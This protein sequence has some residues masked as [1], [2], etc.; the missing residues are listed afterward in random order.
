MRE[1]RLQTTK[2]FENTLGLLTHNVVYLCPDFKFNKPSLLLWKCSPTILI[3][4]NACATVSSKIGVSLHAL[5]TLCLQ[6]RAKFVYI[7][8][9]SCFCRPVWI[10]LLLSF[11]LA[12]ISPWSRHLLLM[13]DTVY[14]PRRRLGARREGGVQLS[15][16][17]DQSLYFCYGELRST[18]LS[19][20]SQKR[21]CRNR[22]TLIVLWRL[23]FV[24]LEVNH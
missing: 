20:L 5:L 22:P 6:T 12:F 23:M 8:G 10:P 4:P 11:F 21:P 9:I 18:S 15:L 13:R 2:R 14:P 3:I 19:L 24:F 7:D 16:V 1:P 17:S